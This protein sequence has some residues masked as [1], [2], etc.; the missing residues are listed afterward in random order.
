MMEF[1]AG[2]AL[3]GIIGVLIGF[4]YGVFRADLEHQI[5]NVK[6]QIRGE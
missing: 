4:I 5:D 1:L 6:K 2:M 3:G